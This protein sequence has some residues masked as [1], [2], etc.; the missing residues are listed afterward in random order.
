MNAATPSFAPQRRQRG[1]TLVEL[2]VGLALGLIVTAA[3][4]TLFA[5][6]STQGQNLNRAS[7]QVEIGRYVSELLT[8]DLRL[9]G[10][11]GELPTT[12]AAYTIPNPCSADP[13]PVGAE[14]WKSVPFTLPNPVQGYGAADPG[15][16]TARRANT[17]AI[18]MRRAS[19][20]T[21][22]VAALA[23]NTQHYVQYSYCDTDPAAIKMVFGKVAADFTLKNRGCTAANPLRA[24]VS[25]I[26]YVAGC[27]RCA[28]TSDSVPTLKR[29]DLVNGELVETALAEG[30]ETL[31]IEY[32][33]DGD[34][35]GSADQFLTA[36]AAAAAVP[37]KN[38]SDVMAVKAHFITRSLS[39]A[40]GSGLATEQTFE[41]GGT[42]TVVTAADGYTRRAYT[43]V[44]R[45]INPSSAREIQ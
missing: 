10:F 41:L 27:N 24:Y 35:N 20:E 40:V 44:I 15:C 29:V 5:N 3:L 23:G 19:A 38:W 36:D 45:L 11:Y 30:V 37:A 42:G 8:E 12:G 18:A 6:A 1:M 26:Y 43:T 33:F 14:N 16:L 2:M 4:L 22:D 13:N 17:D 39:K 34:G 21:T 9:A 31:R 28:P 32:G 7:V 25:R